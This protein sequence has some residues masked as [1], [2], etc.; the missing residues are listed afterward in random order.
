MKAPARST[1]HALAAAVSLAL[2]GAMLPQLA[3]SA[4][5]PAPTVSKAAVKPLQA[6]QAAVNAKNW[7]EALAKLKEVDALPTKTPYDVFVMNQF[8]GIAYVQSGKLAE[9]IPS[10]EAQL[11]SGFLPPE[12]T[13]RIS[14][15]VVSLYY[16][17][18]RFPEAIDAG[19]KIIAAG[20]GNGEVWF[21]VAHSQYFL[22]KHA[23]VVSTV[24]AYLA[25]AAQKG[26]K[27]EE[28]PLLLLVQSQQQLR[29]STGMVDA[30]KVL[31]E[32]YPKVSYWRDMLVIMRDTA[33]GK[34]A[35]SDVVTLNLYRLMRGTDTLRES[36]DYLE[37]AQLA[38]QQG[39]P[40]EAVDAINRG[41]AA[42]AFK[43][44]NEKNAARSQLTTAQKLAE[45]D[46]AGLAKFEAE[47]KAAKGGEGDV[48]LR[49]EDGG[50]AGLVHLPVDPFDV[51]EGGGIER[52]Q[53]ERGEVGRRGG[54]SREHG[55]AVGAHDARRERL[56]LGQGQGLAR[57]VEEL[58]HLP[59][60]VGKE[61]PVAGLHPG[62]LG[63]EDAP[64]PHAHG[65]VER[66]VFVAV[67]GVGALAPVVRLARADEGSH[68]LRRDARLGAV[69]LRE[70]DPAEERLLLDEGEDAG[71][72]RP[73]VE[74]A[75][76]RPAPGVVAVGGE[77][78]AAVGVE[79][80]RQAEL[81][82]V[83]LAGGA[84]GRLACGLHRREQEADE[85][86][87]DGDDHEQFDEREPAAGREGH[88]QLS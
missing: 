83:V 47:A 78:L 76:R 44:E 13:D 11:A 79:V 27:P 7:D 67:D 81:A 53:G 75:H 37:L 64:G 60:P 19:Q 21:M 82:D 4:A 28:N 84:A 17:V 3:V 29:S 63:G 69:A 73:G 16:Q 71:H 41:N 56:H 49:R 42:D 5:P 23:D 38:V 72:R 1:L 34:G 22:D 80:H 40:G 77:G 35:T 15:G 66:P 48:R 10:F 87:D 8:R 68:A 36:V 30:F 9:A 86:A 54:G 31:L 45:T 2:G 51:T 88:G 61:G 33:S 59:A 20:K 25:D 65:V 18:K 58:L 39:S 14:R 46:K 70:V 43:T 24:K 85:R 52:R 26:T 62:G 55:R 32:H 74:R 6:A 57:A 12:D 50:E